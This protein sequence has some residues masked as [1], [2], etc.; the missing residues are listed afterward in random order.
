MKVVL[1]LI[2]ILTS[3]CANPDSLGKLE[4]RLTNSLTS[5]QDDNGAN[6]LPPIYQN[7]LD[8]S[9]CENE[10]GFACLIL[11]SNLPEPSDSDTN[12][13]ASKI[14]IFE[15]GVEIGPAHSLHD[16]IR[17]KG[18][19]HYSHWLG[20]LRLSASDSSNPRTN[21]KKYTF[22]IAGV[23][24]PYVP[25]LEIANFNTTLMG[26]DQVTIPAQKGVPPFTYTVITGGG[27]VTNTGTYK[28][29]NVSSRI[30]VRVTDSAGQVKDVKLRS[31]VMNYIGGGSNGVSRDTVWSSHDGFTWVVQ[32]LL[33]IGIQGISLAVLNDV[34][35]LFGGYTSTPVAVSYKSDNLGNDWLPNTAL[36]RTGEMG[37]RL[38]YGGKIYLAITDRILVSSDGSNYITHA[39]NPLGNIQIDGARM[40]F[41]N[42]KFWLIA[43]G[44][45]G[46]AVL[47]T[48][49]SS[50]DAKTWTL[51]STFPDKRYAG[52]LYN[53]NNKLFYVGGM[54]GNFI[55]TADVFQST[56]GIEWTRIGAIPTPRTYTRGLVYKNKM[57]L[58]GG[59]S[60]TATGERN[61]WSSSDGINWVDSGLLPEGRFNGD[62]VVY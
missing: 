21:G 56:D 4:G 43:G 6:Q 51:V 18:K 17:N 34:L 35:F 36:P 3:A 19:G 62:V 37:A 57:W 50:P 20:T 14:R 41:F 42:N 8:V 10:T 30:T 16:D 15:D 45:R 2:F 38:V 54:S 60:G 27:S 22:G 59:E 24:L 53:F 46:V 33:P 55:V 26:G 58:L 31:Q 44:N 7:P 5:V 49:Y 29:P 48:I 11:V 52:A 61:V 23:Y 13:K 28:A 1:G 9:K 32:K 25:P 39:L 12:P 47:D 40:T